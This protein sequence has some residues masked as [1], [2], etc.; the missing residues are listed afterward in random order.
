[1]P[2]QMRAMANAAKEV[3]ARKMARLVVER[4]MLKKRR[5][6]TT[7]MVMSLLMSLLMSMMM[8]MLLQW[9]KVLWILLRANE[10]ET[11]AAH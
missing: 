8:P 3:Q 1:M 10:R 9:S 7:L 5:R 2:V 6:M 4:L 11:T